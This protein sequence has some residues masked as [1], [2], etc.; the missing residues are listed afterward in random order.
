MPHPLGE[1]SVQFQ[2]TA[3]GGLTG[4]V[5]LPEKLTGT[6]RWKGKSVQLKSGAQTVSL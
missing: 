2:K 4:D 3:T 5:T 1:I 6:L